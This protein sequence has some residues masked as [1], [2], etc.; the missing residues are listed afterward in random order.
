[1]TTRTLL[2]L[3]LTALLTSACGSL[4]RNE[5]EPVLAKYEPYVGEPIRGF[6]SFRLSSWQSVSRTQLILWTGVNEAYL[7]TVWDTCPDLQY[8]ETIRVTSTTSEVST[9]DQVL[10]GNDRCQIQHIQPIDVRRMRADHE[11]TRSQAQ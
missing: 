10:V 3:V 8:T 1:M 6:T 5:Q 4:K 2:V 9:F 11:A 7:V